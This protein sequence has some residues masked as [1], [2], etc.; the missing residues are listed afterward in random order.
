LKEHLRARQSFKVA[1]D[2]QDRGAHLQ[3]GWLTDAIGDASQLFT[4]KRSS[5]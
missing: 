1:T 5:S 4:L 2:I 3:K